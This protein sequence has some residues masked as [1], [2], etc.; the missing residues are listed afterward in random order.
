MSFVDTDKTTENLVLFVRTPHLVF[1]KIP[2]HFF[3]R[4]EILV[5]AS[6]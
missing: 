5:S 4:Q 6:E 3:K 2:L 1:K